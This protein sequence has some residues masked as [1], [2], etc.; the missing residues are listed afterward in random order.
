MEA[1]NIDQTPKT[2]FIQLHATSGMLEM[3]GRSIPENAVDFYTPVFRWMDAY[4]QAAPTAT[5]LHIRFEYFNTSS[6]KCLLDILKKLKALHLSGKSEVTVYWHYEEDDED[7]L[8]AGED[9]QTII[10]IPFEMKKYID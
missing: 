3:R 4:C 5:A 9:F 8:E 6:S 2:P 1:L 10:R 7:M